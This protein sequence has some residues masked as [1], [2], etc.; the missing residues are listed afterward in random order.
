MSDVTDFLGNKLEVDDYFAYA[1]T[2]G[3]SA[4]QAIFQYK[5]K[6]PSG[7][8]KARP[9]SRSYERNDYKVWIN[10]ASDPRWVEGTTRSSCYVDMTDAERAKARAKTSTLNCVPA[11]AVK[12]FDFKE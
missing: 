9:V 12:L 5:G 6:N 7:T 2:L 3:R 4:Q 11:R 10:D 8:Y 1:L